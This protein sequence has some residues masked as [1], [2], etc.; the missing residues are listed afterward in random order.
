MAAPRDI[1]DALE[2]VLSVY[3]AGVRRNLRAAL[4]PCDATVEAATRT[5]A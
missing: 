2:R 4:I 3:F 1:V 5:K